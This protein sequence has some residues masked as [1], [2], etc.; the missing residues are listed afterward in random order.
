MPRPPRKISGNSPYAAEW[1]ILIDYLKSVFPRHSIGVQTDHTVHGTFRRARP[2]RG[3]GGGTHWYPFK[4][5]VSGANPN[6]PDLDWRTFRVRGGKIFFDSA[7]PTDVTGTDGTNDDPEGGTPTDPGTDRFTV[8]EDILDYYVWLEYE[9]IGGA[10]SA[11]VVADSDPATN[12]WGDFPTLDGHHFLI[13]HI[14][15]QT[16]LEEKQAKIRQ[17]QRDDLKFGP[18]LGVC[19]PDG[20]IDAS[21]ATAYKRPMPITADATDITAD[22]TRFTADRL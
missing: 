19:T 15:T 14:D 16:K 20:L 6:D 12:G 8:P 10:W 7:D 17:Y 5:Y 21:V 3:G 2:G 18:M 22:M 4:I 11:T 1:N 13:A 9:Y